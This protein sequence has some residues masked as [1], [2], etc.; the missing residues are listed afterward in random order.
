MKK[1]KRKAFNFLRS[2]YDVFNK[3]QTDA[4]K[5]K[6]IE[7][8]LDKQFLDVDPND[9]D[10]IVDLAFESQRHQIE[11][12]VKGYKSKS[13]DPMQGGCQDPTQGGTQGVTQGGTQGAC[14]Q[15]EE[16]EQEKEKEEVQEKEEY[17]FIINISNENVL[18]EY[19]KISFSYWKLFKK[20]LKDSGLSNTKNLDKATINT[21]AKIVKLMIEKDKRTIEELKT[22]FR[23]LSENEFWK[24]NVQSIST[25]RR[26]FERLYISSQEKQQSNNNNIDSSY[27]ESLKNRLS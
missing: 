19:E 1:T 2:Y 24:K 7:C 3:L 23:F 9:I 26:Q 13:K 20:N 11:N 21:W 18:N 15:E 4:Q 16:K 27:V 17:K 8:L 14:L 5:L 25:L 12:S 22:V 6:F 10:F